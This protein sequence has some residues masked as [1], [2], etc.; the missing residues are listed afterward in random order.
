MKTINKIVKFSVAFIVCS[1]IYIMT[2]GIC[3]LISLYDW[4]RAKR[5]FAEFHFINDMREF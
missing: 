1:I 2:T 4:E 3:C 5:E